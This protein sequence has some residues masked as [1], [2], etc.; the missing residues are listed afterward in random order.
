MT[1][2]EESKPTAAERAQDRAR[3]AYR[4]QDMRADVTK[5]P[6]AL[7]T[8]Q[9]YIEPAYEEEIDTEEEA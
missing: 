7:T 5:L 4:I 9:L 2:P 3:A 1:Q 6:D 8:Q